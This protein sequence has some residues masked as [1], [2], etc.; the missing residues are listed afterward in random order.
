MRIGARRTRAHNPSRTRS[1]LC[2]SLSYPFELKPFLVPAS[3][4]RT[5]KIMPIILAPCLLRHVSERRVAPGTAPFRGHGKSPGR[6]RRSGVSA[7]FTVLCTVNAARV[8][9]NE[10][11]EGPDRDGRR[12]G[13]AGCDRPA[14]P[15]SRPCGPE[16]GGG[17]ARPPDS[18]VLERPHVRN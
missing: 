5:T 7:A 18:A 3:P 15:A 2:G 13:G 4:A 17:R 14:S 10:V 8:D 12:G 1:S 11:R 9:G 16:A 6:V